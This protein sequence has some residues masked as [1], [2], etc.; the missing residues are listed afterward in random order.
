MENDIA[1][2]KV[3]ARRP[4]FG[5]DNRNLL[6]LAGSTPRT[7]RGIQRNGRARVRSGRQES[8]AEI[9]GEQAA[10]RRP[11]ANLAR[12]VLLPQETLG[13]TVS[14]LIMTYLEALLDQIEDPGC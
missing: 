7:G 8:A 3:I 12:P 4:W 9:Q 14:W 2:K 10:G 1:S 13:G 5:V 6:F 11:F